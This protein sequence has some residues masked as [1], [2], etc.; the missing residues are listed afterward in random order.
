MANE[1]IAARI[2][3][4]VAAHERGDTGAKAVAD[5]IELYEPALE[6]IPRAV[7]DELHRLSVEL[8]REDV[9]PLE[10]EMLGWERTRRALDELKALL[11][12][13]K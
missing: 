12:S 11:V 5:S 3:E 4:V 10:A 13:F 7:R 6:G 8:I 9:T 2:A 1:S